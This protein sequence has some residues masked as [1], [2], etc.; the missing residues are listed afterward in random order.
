MFDNAWVC[1]F[2]FIGIFVF[3]LLAIRFYGWGNK[4]Y[5]NLIT[6]EDVKNINK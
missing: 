6:E 1:L 4:G 3:P 2:G 5:I